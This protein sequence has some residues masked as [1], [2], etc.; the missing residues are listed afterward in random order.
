[1]RRDAY[2]FDIDGTLADCGHRRHHVEGPKK[3]WDAFFRG[4]VDDPPIKAMVRLAQDLNRTSVSL[5][6]A[7]GRPIQ[8]RLETIAWLQSQ[9]LGLGA[10]NLYMRLDEDR[11]D[12]TIVKSEMLDRIIADGF[13]PIMVFD[14][15]NRVVQMWRARGLICAHVA[16]GDF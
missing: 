4:C 1:M 5:V 9:G 13:D 8:Y 15:R 3:D 12:D 14:D 7:T 16:D 10:R 6:F 11:R 2:I